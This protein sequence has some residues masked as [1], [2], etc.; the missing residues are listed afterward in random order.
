MW[1]HAEW[2]LL[3]GIQV[4]IHLTPPDISPHDSMEIIP[5]LLTFLLIH[6]L[7]D[8]YWDATGHTEK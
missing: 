7:L 2:E 8:Y 6:A 4:R 1:G 3:P 5:A